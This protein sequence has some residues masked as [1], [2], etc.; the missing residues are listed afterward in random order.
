MFTQSSAY[1]RIISIIENFFGLNNERPTI[2]YTLAEDGIACPVFSNQMMAE[3]VEVRENA[4][5]VN[6]HSMLLTEFAKIF[7]QLQLGRNA[8]S[9]FEHMGI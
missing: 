6:I 8:T 9:I 4:D 5:W 2:N 7:M 3:D 1:K